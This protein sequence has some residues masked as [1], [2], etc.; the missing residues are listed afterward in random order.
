M[1]EPR[2][3]ALVIRIP[4]LPTTCNTEEEEDEEENEGSV[5]ISEPKS[6]VHREAKD[7]T[8]PL[9]L[10]S[11]SGPKSKSRLKPT[12][13]ESEELE[14]MFDEVGMEFLDELVPLEEDD[15]RR[16]FLPSALSRQ[17]LPFNPISFSHSHSCSIYPSSSSSGSSQ[18]RY[19]G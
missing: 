2:D 10:P 3:I 8:S 5:P 6:E 12:E 4:D 1:A 17:S 19:S 13:A 9:P 15:E 14:E 16:K 11:D 7:E 18:I